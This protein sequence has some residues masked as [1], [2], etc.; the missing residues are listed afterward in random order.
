MRTWMYKTLLFSAFTASF[1]TSATTDKDVKNLKGQLDAIVNNHIYS[2][3]GL[4]KDRLLSILKTLEDLNKGEIIFGS[5]SAVAHM[6]ENINA[7]MNRVKKH[8]RHFPELRPYVYF[9]AQ[10]WNIH[11]PSSPARTPARTLR[12]LVPASPRNTPLASSQPPANT[13][14]RQKMLA[15]IRARRKDDKTNG[16]NSPPPPPP[17]LPTSTQ[18]STLAS[19]ANT[20]E[21]QKMLAAIR[22]RRKD[23]KTNGSNSPPATTAASADFHAKQHTRITRKHTGHTFS[24]SKYA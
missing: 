24:S 4:D 16:S 9:H 2:H 3:V 6:M 21:R 5:Q 12:S 8:F 20:P 22:A 19:P 14:E 1:L 23:D 11:T 13:P 7:Q 15:A 17:P 18:N 10:N